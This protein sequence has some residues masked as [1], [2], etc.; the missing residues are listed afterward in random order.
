MRRTSLA[1]DLLSVAHVAGRRRLR[2]EGRLM[3]AAR[4]ATPVLPSALP[5]PKTARPQRSRTRSILCPTHDCGRHTDAVAVPKPLRRES[6]DSEANVIA[7]P[8]ALM[9]NARP[10]FDAL[11]HRGP[12]ALSS[13]RTVTA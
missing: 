13:R 6:A 11:G 8:R 9:E 10:F 5:F 4:A 2:D 7:G 12:A 1:R 3:T